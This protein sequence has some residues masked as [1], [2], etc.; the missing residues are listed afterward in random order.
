[1]AVAIDQTHAPAHGNLGNAL[2]G[3]GR[4]DE[5]IANYDKAIA[6][7]PDFADAFGNRGGALRQLKRYEE[8]V[9]SCDKAI[10]LRP[11]YME[12]H[13]NR[14]SALCDLNRP[15]EAIASCDKAIA[16]APDYVDAHRNRGTALHDLQRHEEAIACLDRAIALDPENA[17]A[18]WNQ[19]LC[20]LQIANFEAGWD[21][22]EWRWRGSETAPARVYDQP[23]WLGKE[24]ISGKTLFVHWEQGL[25][26]TIHFCRYVYLLKARGVKTILQVQQPLLSLLKQLGDAAEIVGPDENI[27]GFDYH[28]H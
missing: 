11:D 7:D 8:A 6:L 23:L 1:M 19:S 13:A 27:H 26:D 25:G 4:H 12:A 10:A 9:A 22:H 28:C 21:L 20:Y 2:Q 14:G 5:A 15:D 24:D 18:H 17:D 16:L 3:S